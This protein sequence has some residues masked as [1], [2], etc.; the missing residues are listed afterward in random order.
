MSRCPRPVWIRSRARLSHSVGRGRFPKS[1]ALRLMRTRWGLMEVEM[2]CVGASK[3]K[4][5]CNQGL[6]PLIFTS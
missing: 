5:D 1:P 3:G 2:A 6:N 4:I